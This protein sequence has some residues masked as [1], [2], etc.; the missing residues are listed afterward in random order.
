VTSVRS[1]L[2]T[3]LRSAGT[4]GPRVP[5]WW[6]TPRMLLVVALAA[7]HLARRPGDHAVW[8]PVGLVLVATAAEPL[9]RRLLPEQVAANVPGF[10]PPTVPAARWVVPSALVALLV[11]AVVVAAGSPVRWGLLGAGIQLVVTA[12]VAAQG[13]RAYAARSASAAALRS[14]LEA[15]RPEF[16]V[17]TARRGGAYQLAMWLPHLRAVGRPFLIVTRDSAAVPVLAEVTDAPVVACPR[18][19]DLDRVAVPSL[20]AAFYV[21]SVAANADFVTYRGLVHVY[22]G[23]GESDKALSHHPAH[24][25]YDKVFVSGRAAVERYARHG[26]HVPDDKFVVVGSPQSSAVAPARGGG[27][28]AEPVVLYAP[29]WQGYNDHSSYSSLRLGPRI[30]T[31]LLERSATVVFRPHPFSRTRDSERGH[32]QAV[33]ALLSRDAAASGRPHVWAVDEP[34]A[35]SANRADALVAD[36]SSILTEWLAADKPV[37]VVADDDL[38]TFRER[39]PV[40][41][42]AYLVDRDLANLATVLDDLLGT[43]PLAPE[44][45]TVRDH[46][47]AVEGDEPFRQ[48]VLQLLDGPGGVDRSGEATR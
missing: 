31:A 41:R 33:E 30:V 17:Y 39:H 44:R 42:A 6:S 18:W 12:L 23:H 32:V 36:L 48:A 37:A 8:L 4:T 3:L 43:D 5:G 35:A 28:P 34:F 13:L 19:R 38:A 46:Y 24:A 9:L 20:R 16:A 25:M 2:G 22:L 29:T 1:L 40:A 45:R 26:V 27:V 15:H 14:A 11:L 47:V 7:V 10:R 21:N